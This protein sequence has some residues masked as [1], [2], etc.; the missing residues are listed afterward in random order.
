MTNPSPQ[1]PPRDS[2]GRE[3]FRSVW[4]VLTH[5][6]GAK[7]L[8]L[9]I[10]V[11]LWAGLITQDPSL[12]REKTFTDVTISVSGTDSIKRNG[13]I[14]VSDLSETLGGA[15]LK[16]DV[17][18]MQYQNAQAG[19]Y[20]AR[21]DLSRITQTGVQEVRVL[22][23]NSTAYG[24][25]SEISPA[26]LEIEVEEYI[27]RYRIFN[28]QFCTARH[29][30]YFHV[31]I[32]IAENLVNALVKQAVAVDITDVIVDC[33]RF[34]G[35]DGKYLFSTDF[36]N[37]DLS[38]TTPITETHHKFSFVV[39]AS[40]IVNFFVKISVFKV[41]RTYNLCI[42]NYVCDVYAVKIAR[43]N[44]VVVD[45]SYVAYGRIIAVFDS[46]GTAV[47]SVP[48]IALA[49]ERVVS[50][51]AHRR[52]RSAEHAVFNV[53]VIN[54]HRI[55][56][57]AIACPRRKRNSVTAE[58][59]AV[60]YFETVHRFICFFALFTPDRQIVARVV[61]SYRQNQCVVV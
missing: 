38:Y 37:A 56:V 59:V 51:Y 29:E 41:L 28:K 18:Q 61:G 42:G 48:I 13:F 32:V 45:N 43:R 22:T 47:S 54:T 16:V 4:R 5:N 35:V 1:Q 52:T 36:F 11:V 44:V 58:Q 24:S 6:W 17:P 19:Y 8:S 2:R 60:Y 14:V 15:T 40:A 39:K 53:N 12:T 25:V 9:V 50:P 57:A 10:A 20:N 33:H 49:V 34:F 21:I 46:V 27:T 55:L 3:V 31:E 26:T 23:T 30:F 7:I